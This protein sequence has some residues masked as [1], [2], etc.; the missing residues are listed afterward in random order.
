M[1]KIC[2][3]NEDTKVDVCWMIVMWGHDDNKTVITVPYFSLFDYVSLL[4]YEPELMYE[5]ELNKNINLLWKA[6]K[7]F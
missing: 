6:L 5:I 7:W 2:M 4:S 1:N 3:A